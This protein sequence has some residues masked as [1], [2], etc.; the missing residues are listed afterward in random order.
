MIQEAL[1]NNAAQWTRIGVMFNVVPAD[2]TPDL[3]RLLIDTARVADQDPRLFG[4]AATW[5]SRYGHFVAKHRLV[6][7]I[8]EE[9]NAPE[10]ALFGLLVGFARRFGKKPLLSSVLR[11]CRPLVNPQPLFAVDRSSPAFAKLVADHASG[12]SR[13]W[14]LWTDEL[15]PSYDALRPVEW[16]LAQNQAFRVRARFQCDLRLS[17]LMCLKYESLES[18]SEAELVR[19]C[20]VTRAAMHKALDI[21]WQADDIRRC[22]LRR[23]YSI[24]SAA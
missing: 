6:R 23:G 5:L 11:V 15:E 19:R 16:V 20:G 21:L 3:E 8:R 4:M 2:E 14:G 12:I 22:R 18:A 13:E 17:V 9:L 1:E 24:G 10:Q 7:M